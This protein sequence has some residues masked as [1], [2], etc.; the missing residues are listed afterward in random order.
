VSRRRKLEVVYGAEIR[1]FAELNMTMKIHYCFG[2]DRLLEM[3]RRILEG[4]EVRMGAFK[5]DLKTLG[6]DRVTS[7]KSVYFRDLSVTVQKLYLQRL[8]GL[9]VTERAKPC[10]GSFGF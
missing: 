7:S 2:N 10:R 3:D 5:G 4:A 9:A 6:V 8:S 1:C